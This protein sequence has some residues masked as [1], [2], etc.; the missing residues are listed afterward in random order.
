MFYKSND[1][2]LFPELLKV[3]SSAVAFKT[4]GDMDESKSAHPRL[5]GTSKRSIHAGKEVAAR[6]METSG[7]NLSLASS[8]AEALYDWVRLG[9]YYMHEIEVMP[10][11]FKAGPDRVAH[12]KVMMLAERLG[13]EVQFQSKPFPDQVCVN[14][15]NDESL[16]SKVRAL[17][18]GNH[19]T[20]IEELLSIQDMLT[21]VVRT[22]L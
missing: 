14:T 21:G 20:S 16:E 2:E 18:K 11:Q 5:K 19:G 4:S 1:T 6:V 22:L 17:I 9:T 3:L 13:V 15:F 8:N 12:D 7:S 10:E